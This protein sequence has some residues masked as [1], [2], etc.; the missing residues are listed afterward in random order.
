MGKA[1]TIMDGMKY[2]LRRTKQL[3]QNIS[4]VVAANKI[5]N[6][7]VPIDMFS[8]TTKIINEAK[9]VRQVGLKKIWQGAQLPLAAGAGGG[10]GL[11]ATRSSDQ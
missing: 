9:R 6:K 1:E 8:D 11:A 4:E 2:L 10:L 5:V 3:P 7:K